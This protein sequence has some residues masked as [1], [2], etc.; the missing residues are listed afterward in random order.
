MDS[1]EADIARQT[2]SMPDRVAALDWARMEASLET[3]G[4]ATTSP[5]ISPEGCMALTGLYDHVLIDSPPLLLVAD[6]LELARIVDGVVVVARRN[7][8]TSEEAKEVRS[9]V[10][11]LGLSLVGVVLTDVGPSGAYYNA[12]EPVETPQP[13]P[14]ATARTDDF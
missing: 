14:V 7:N 6:S 1:I 11:R 3:D 10:Q 9:L 5:L 13:L 2:A 12:Y 8:V 4:Y